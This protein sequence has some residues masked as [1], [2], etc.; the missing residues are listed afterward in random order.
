MADREAL[1]SLDVELPR[2]PQLEHSVCQFKGCASSDIWARGLC[3]R[4]YQHWRRYGSLEAEK[5]AGKVTLD[6]DGYVKWRGRSVHR[7][8]LFQHIG[9]GPHLCH[10]CGAHVNW[11]E[12]A[13]GSGSW[14]GVLVVDHMDHDRANN[15]PSNLV[16]ACFKCNVGR[17]KKRA[18][19]YTPFRRDR[20]AR[21]GQ[22]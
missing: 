8:V 16:P 21:E 5:R 2:A 12:G 18:H 20:G 17:T 9:W 3:S 10:W 1:S 11:T 19:L 4:H 15:R 14:D 22:G 6:E 13:R 7:I